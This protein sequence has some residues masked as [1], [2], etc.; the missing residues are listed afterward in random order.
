MYHGRA[1]ASKVLKPLYDFQSL[2]PIADYS[3]PRALHAHKI[4]DYSPE[5]ERRIMSGSLVAKDSVEEQ[6]IRAQAINAQIKLLKEVNSHRDRKATFVELDYKLWMLGRSVPTPHH[7]D[8][9]ILNDATRISQKRMQLCFAWYGRRQGSKCRDEHHLVERR[10]AD[11]R[12]YR[13]RPRL[14]RQRRPAC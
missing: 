8:H 6:E 7:S 3:I 9:S 11:T 5:L 14:S 2:G 12:I 13:S 10:P 4:L 1:I